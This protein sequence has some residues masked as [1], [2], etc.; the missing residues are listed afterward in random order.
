M[1]FN[2]SGAFLFATNFNAGK[3]HVSGLNFR[4]VRK[5]GMFSDPP[6]PSGFAPFGISAI[7]GNL[8]VTYAQQNA[9]KKDDAAGPGHGFVNI[10]DTQGNLVRRFA[11][12]GQLNSPWGLAWVPFEGFGKFDNALLVGNFGDGSINAY[13][14]YSGK[15][16][17]KVNDAAGNPINIPGVC[18]LQFSLGVAKAASDSL[19][20]SA[21]IAE[22]KHGL[23]GTLRVNPSSVAP[24]EGPAMVD[25]AHVFPRQCQ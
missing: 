4:P 11:S 10:F 1:G 25:Q 16:L 8:Y 19:F 9:A 22:E 3:V 6:I 20:F 5:D 23:V 18:A 7:N 24:P 12:Q 15:S 2:E 21:G 17:G 14:F 13:D